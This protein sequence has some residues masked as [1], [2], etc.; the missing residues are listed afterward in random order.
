[1]LYSMSPEDGS[2]LGKIDIPAVEKKEEN[3]FGSSSFERIYEFL[4]AAT[5]KN[6]F[7]LMPDEPDTYNVM[8]LNLGTKT[9]KKLSITVNRNEMYYN[10]FNLSSDGIISALLASEYDAKLVWWRTE[11]LIGEPRK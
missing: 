3:S 7:F 9:M 6:L 11:K 5:G 1:L 10:A 2:I 4:G 8:I